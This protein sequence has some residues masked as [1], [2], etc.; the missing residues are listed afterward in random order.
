MDLTIPGKKGGKDTITQIRKIDNNFKVIVSSG[1]S[2][3]PVMSNYQDYGFNGIL[4][5]PYRFEDL[6]QIIAAISY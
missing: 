4:P 6:K 3:D 5:K 1:Y 2:N